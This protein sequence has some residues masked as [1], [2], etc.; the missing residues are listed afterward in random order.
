MKH[1]VI[2]FFF[3][4][5]FFLF[6]LW[7]HKCNNKKEDTVSL[8]DLRTHFSLK[9]LSGNIDIDYATTRSVL[10]DVS[11]QELCFHCNCTITI[12][13]IIKKQKCVIN[14]LQGI[15]TI[16]C[17]KY[18][19]ICPVIKFII[20]CLFIIKCNFCAVELSLLF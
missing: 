2:K 17:V 12:Y 14:T 4:V 8:S 20:L 18:F 15:F 13:T 1:F 9:I 6:W 19:K 3:R 11:F 16:V 10:V 5:W 7:L